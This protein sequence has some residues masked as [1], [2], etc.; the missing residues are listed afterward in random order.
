[1]NHIS[2]LSIVF[3]IVVTAACSQ[4]TTLTILHTND[5]HATVY[6]H[7]AAWI[8]GE[9]KPLVGGF[10]EL[11][12]TV[13]SIRKANPNTLLLDGGD[14]MTGSPISDYEY[15]G[16]IGGAIFDMMNMLGYDAWTIG[17]HDLDISQDNLRALTKVAKFPTLNANLMDSSGH[18]HLNNIPYT[19]VQRNGLKIGIIGLMSD[20]LFSLVNTKNLL[21]I[22]LLQGISVAEELIK[23]L[24]PETD[25]LIAI[26][27]RGVSED[28]LLAEAVDGLDVIVGGHSHTRLRQPKVVN[29]VIIVQAGSNCENLGV[30]EVVVENDKVVSHKGK[31]IQLWE[32][33][34]RASPEMMALLDEFKTKIDKEYNEA[35]GTLSEDWKRSGK[36]HSLGNFYTDA[37]R[38]AAGAQVAFANSTGIRKDLLAGEV[39]K[40]DLIEIAPFRNYLCTFELSGKQLREIIQKHVQTLIDGGTRNHL[41]GVR[42]WWKNVKGKAAIVSVLIDGKELDESK[43][44]RCAAHDYFLNQVDKYLEVQPLSKECTEKLMFDVLVE[45]V[46]KEKQLKTPELRFIEVK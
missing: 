8:H 43:I 42:C 41:S 26:T 35:I 20:D 11:W 21:G 16:A 39:T 25:L 12:W 4:P 28:S 19:I 31:L 3:L 17:N 30:L 9:P 37:I 32:R 34:H 14:V 27:H 7:E 38:E 22:K 45:K 44:Y 1:M 24:D 40:L 6:P 13:D 33:G 46:K 5:I 15:K 18:Y 10:A 36:E 29:G 23:K 2:K